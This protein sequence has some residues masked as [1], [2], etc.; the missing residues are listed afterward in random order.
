LFSTSIIA[1]AQVITN[2]APGQA[3]NL[4]TV[5][6]NGLQIQ[7]G[8]KLFADFSFSYSDL[9]LGGSGDIPLVSSN[10]NLTALSNI[11]GYGLEFTQ[12]L[13]AIG[14]KTKDVALRYSATVT[15]PNFLISDVHLAITGAAGNG[16][17]GSVGESVFV[18][19]FGANQVGTLQATLPHSSNDVTTALIVPPVTQLYVEKD[20]L[21]TGGSA[22]NGFATVTI[23]DQTFSQI[24]EPSTALL[25]GLGLL[26]VV[27]LKR[28]RHS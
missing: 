3:I 26:A 9:T 7:I 21:V 22:A 11:I 4:A 12:P 5:I 15:D 25:V 2:L 6:N 20:V 16:G 27:A 14:Q 1:R 8:D 13:S 24:P 10:V 18:G 28:K 23:I 19:G 17:L